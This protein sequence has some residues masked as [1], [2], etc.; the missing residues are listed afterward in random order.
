MLE[1]HRFAAALAALALGAAAG[2]ASCAAGSESVP[3]TGGGAT[4]SSST[5]GTGGGA[6]TTTSSASGTGGSGTGGGPTNGCK[7][8]DEVVLAI[9]RLY[10]GDTNWDDTQNTSTGWQLFGLNIDGKS[11][12]GSSTDTCKPAGGGAASVTF[13]DGPNGLDNSFGKNVLPVFTANI[14][15]LSA[16]ANAALINGDFSILIRM[17]GLD[18][19]PTQGAIPA[20]VYGGA[21]LDLP[22]T[23]DGSDCWPVAPESLSNPADVESAKA[24]YP[25]TSLNLNRWD[26]VSTGDLDL[27]LQV[28]GFQG[29]AIIHQ[30]RIVMDLDP[31]HN[32]TQKGIISGVLDTEE[33]ITAIKKLMASF[34]PQACQG[35][36]FVQMIE[37]SIRQASDIMKDGTQDPNATCNGISIGLGFKAARVQFGPIGDALPPQPDPCMP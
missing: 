21:Y 33:F 9:D 5:T 14:P 22:P 18:S 30:A 15:S 27:T 3:G 13:P 36:A 1:R 34:D 19:G 28:L 16:Q 25:S 23:F 32:G 12:T 31:D 37:T 29:H 2:A 6:T 8:A 35:G 7:A 11:S 10:F 17:I 26:S 20:K 24:S 4:T